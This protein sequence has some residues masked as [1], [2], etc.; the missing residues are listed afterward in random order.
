MRRVPWWAVL[1]SGCAPVL[2][3]GGWSVATLLYGQGYE[4]VTQT[5]SVLAADGA[6]GYWVMTGM[7][8]ALGVCHLVTAWGLRPAALAGR[9]ALGAGGVT[10]MVLVLSPAPRSGGSLGHGAV[11][12]VGFTFLALWPI[13]AA[14]RSRAAPWGLQPRVSVAVTA[15]MWVGAAWFLAE[16]LGHGQAGVAERALTTAQSLWPFVVVASCLRHSRSR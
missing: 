8:I 13:L 7:L 4:P 3:V 16:L 6:S 15:L 9:V 10:A 5:I 14:V 11:V 2:L 12:A 1:S